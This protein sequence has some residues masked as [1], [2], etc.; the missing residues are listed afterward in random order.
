ARTIF[1]VLPF[2]RGDCDNDGRVSIADL[3][4]GITVELGGDAVAACSA[5]DLNDDDSV[6]IDELI[7]A[8]SDALTG[9]VTTFTPTA[10]PKDTPTPVDLGGACRSTVECRQQELLCLEPGG[11]AGCVTC[12]EQS[13]ECQQDSDCTSRGEGM[14]CEEIEIAG[15]ECLCFRTRLCIPGCAGDTDCKVGQQCNAAAHCIDRPCQADRDCPTH[16]H[17]YTGGVAVNGTCAR[18]YCAADD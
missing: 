13:D 9:C 8:V 5:V 10:T 12:R 16:F 3:V 14:I 15:P 4:R 7:A 6:T 11:F 2:C 17:C 1:T 18:R